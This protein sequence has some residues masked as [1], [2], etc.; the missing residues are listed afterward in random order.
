[1]YHF[2]AKEVQAWAVLLLIPIAW[3]IWAFPFRLAFCDIETRRALFVHGLDVVCDV[4]FVLDIIGKSIR[5]FCM[6]SVGVMNAG[7]L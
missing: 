6:P 7:K 2:P 3:E 4:W 5:P 1:M